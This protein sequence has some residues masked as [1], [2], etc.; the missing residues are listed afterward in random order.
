[1][2]WEHPLG[3]KITFVAPVSATLKDFVLDNLRLEIFVSQVMAKH[4]KNV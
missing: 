4:H 1:L 3:D 2:P